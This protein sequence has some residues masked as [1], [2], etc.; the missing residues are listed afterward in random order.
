MANIAQIAII[1]GGASGMVAAITAA[2]QLQKQ[3][4]AGRI[5]LLEKE[6]RVGKKL[7]ATGNGRCNLSNQE[8]MPS[9]YHGDTAW[10]TPILERFPTKL[11]V[12]SFEKMGLLCR[13]DS[14]GRVY[15][16][17]LQASAVLEILRLQMELYQIEVV[18]AFAVE[19]IQKKQTQFV[20]TSQSGDQWMAEKV[21]LA[22]GGKAAPKL[23]TDGWGTR[24]AKQL[25]HTIVQ[26]FPALVQLKSEPNRMKLIKGMRSQAAVSLLVNGKVCMEEKGEVQF[27]EHGLSGICIFQFSGNANK[28]LEQGANVEVSLDLMPEWSV[29]QLVKRIAGQGKRYEALPALDLLCGFVN[30]RVGQAVVKEALGKQMPNCAGD[31][32]YDQYRQI[33]ETVKAFRFPITGSMGWESAQVT[34]GGVHCKEINNQTMES[35]L[36]RG[37][38][39]TGELIDI[40]GDCGGFNLHFAWSSGIA[41]G[42]ACVNT[43][44][45]EEQ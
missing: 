11:I 12:Q 26:E 4:K 7:L 21:I 9:H 32:T 36:C 38:Y 19:S 22:A 31:C 24:L 40:Y 25:G 35:K 18:C 6:N 13:T 10:V 27:T 29:D 43:L 44:Q 1:G 39:L 28:L 14:E 17:N 33:A 2:Q 37:L 34:A 45:E 3:K 16:Y 41:A 8:I 5:V 42:S 30:Q 23:G 15:P 20:I